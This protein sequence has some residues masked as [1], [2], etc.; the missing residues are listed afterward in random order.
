VA[1]RDDADCQEKDRILALGSIAELGLLAPLAS[2]VVFDPEEARD[3]LT[4]LCADVRAS[5]NL[6]PELSPIV[7]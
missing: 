4:R 6:F 3:A 1:Q 5:P 2:G 7:S